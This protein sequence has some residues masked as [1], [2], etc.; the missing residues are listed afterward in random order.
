[1]P[2]RHTARSPRAR[3][4]ASSARTSSSRCTSAKSS[5]CTSGVRFRGVAW[6]VR[7]IASTAL[8]SA[9]D[10]YSPPAVVPSRYGYN[11]SA[12]RAVIR[13]ATAP[14]RAG[15]GATT[16]AAPASRTSCA[17]ASAARRRSK[18]TAVSSSSA[19]RFATRSST[20]RNHGRPSVSV[21]CQWWLPNPTARYSNDAI[22][23][24]HA[25]ASAS[26]NAVSGR[27]GGRVNI[28]ASYGGGDQS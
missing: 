12:Y 6:S 22:G 23:S 20:V 19:R 11:A 1:M 8:R 5:T 24:S 27:P 9:A 4:S 25:A 18:T 16:K 2:A 7:S 3:P 15:S 28:C 14:S 13:R 10:E 17:V 26:T 21:A